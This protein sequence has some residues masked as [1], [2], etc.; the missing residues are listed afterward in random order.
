MNRVNGSRVIVQ[1]RPP[2]AQPQII[3]ESWAGFNAQ[4]GLSKLVLRS[5]WN[6]DDELKTLT[7][8]E[9]HRIANGFSVLGPLPDQH[10]RLARKWGRDR[11]G[12][13]MFRRLVIP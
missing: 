3:V 9:F 4:T 7:L 8:I 13:S 11:W 10:K 1:P 5:L 2:T 12:G 6:A